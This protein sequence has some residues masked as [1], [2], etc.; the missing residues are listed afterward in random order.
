VLIL[1]TKRT[2]R[3]KTPWTINIHLV[4]LKNEGQ[5]GKTNLFWGWVTVGDGGHKEMGNKGVFG[6]CGLYPYMKIEE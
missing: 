5:E 3:A 4:F 1:T 6:G 2:G